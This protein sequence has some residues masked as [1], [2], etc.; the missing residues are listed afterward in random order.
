MKVYPAVVMWNQCGAIANK[1]I[2]LMNMQIVFLFKPLQANAS[3][4]HPL[5]T[6]EN[7]WFSGVFSGCKMGALA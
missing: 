2:S 7:L 5:K 1:L 6:L 4:L 3:I